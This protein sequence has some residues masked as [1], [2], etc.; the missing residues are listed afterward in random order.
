MRSNPFDL[1]VSDSEDDG[2][3]AFNNIDSVVEGEAAQD[4]TYAGTGAYYDDLVENLADYE[5]EDVDVDAAYVSSPPLS[6]SRSRFWKALTSC[7]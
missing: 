4:R 2:E 7:C 5:E 1:A 3:M 6:P